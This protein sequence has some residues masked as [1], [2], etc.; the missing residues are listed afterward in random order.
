MGKIP[1][2][3]AGE[4]D[5]PI[6]P[7]TIACLKEGICNLSFGSYQDTASSIQAWAKKHLLKSEL[8]YEPSA[9]TDAINQLEEYFEGNRHTFELSLYLC[10]TPFQLKVWD[11]LQEIPY[12]ETKTYKEVAQMIGKPKAV[13]AVGTANNRNPIPII[14][15][16]HRVIGSNGTL[17]G[18]GGGIDKKEHLLEVE[19]IIKKE[20]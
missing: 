4:M 14:I 11:A 3:F 18:Y 8:K 20:S 19:G 5:S 6:G 16:C 13:R 17:V 1:Y 9:L 7:L 10:G 2:I 12:G 15:P